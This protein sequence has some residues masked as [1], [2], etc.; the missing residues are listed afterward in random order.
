MSTITSFGQGL[1]NAVRVDSVS[2]NVFGRS[3]NTN[4]YSLAAGD[5]DPVSKIP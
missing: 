4:H 5:E 3:P 2:L 1:G